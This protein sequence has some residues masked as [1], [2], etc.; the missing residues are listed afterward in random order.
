M[1]FSYTGLIPTAH[2]VTH[3]SLY[4]SSTSYLESQ[5]NPDLCFKSKAL[6]MGQLCPASS[7]L[8]VITDLDKRPIVAENVNVSTQERT[9]RYK[10]TR[11]HLSSVLDLV[12]EF[13]SG[14]RFRL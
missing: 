11:V 7:T 14:K 13:L 4:S 2:R 10:A 12:S 3:L 8:S 9:V 6:L 1:A 5:K